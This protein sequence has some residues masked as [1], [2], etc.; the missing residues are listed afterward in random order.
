MATLLYP[1]PHSRACNYI[2][3]RWFFEADKS[4]CIYKC[5]HQI[6]RGKSAS[7]CSLVDRQK[8]WEKWK[9]FRA[10][11]WGNTGIFTIS[12]NFSRRKTR[13][14]AFQRYFHET[15]EWIFWTHF[16]CMHHSHSFIHNCMH[17]NEWNRVLSV[18]S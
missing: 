15:T 1:P 14:R 7:G 3:N 17:V 6:I 12:P 16:W 18:A 4:F 2:R 9:I 8:I 13:F 5:K 11:I 10:T